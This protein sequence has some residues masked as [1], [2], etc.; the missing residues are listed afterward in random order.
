MSNILI[1]GGAGFI[2]S[3]LA[4]KLCKQGH[5]IV[6]VDNMSYGHEDNLKFDDI[7]LSDYLINGDIRDTEMMESLFQS[8]KPDYVYNIAGIAPLPDCQSNPCEA[9][10][11]NVNGFVNI[12]ECSR[13]YGVK[14]VIQASTNAMYENEY[15]FVIT[16]YT[17]VLQK[18]SKAFL[19]HYE[20]SPFYINLYSCS[21]LMLFSCLL[22]NSISN[23]LNHLAFIIFPPKDLQ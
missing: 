19:I 13:K 10:S 22:F 21:S 16:E 15:R 17:D 11:I 18:N 23:F 1:T 9:V 8:F 3:Q 5:D 7:N 4:Y 2:G 6:I 12:L 14:T 20:N